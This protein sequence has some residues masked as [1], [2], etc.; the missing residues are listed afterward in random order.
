MAPGARRSRQQASRGGA[1]RTARARPLVVCASD[2]RS[3]AVR[4]SASLR[5]GAEVERIA[6]KRQPSDL[7]LPT[8]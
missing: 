7:P 8:T 1:S 3:D 4:S 5:R 2:V 6:A